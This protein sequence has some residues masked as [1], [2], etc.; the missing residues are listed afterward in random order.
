MK[1]LSE[2]TNNQNEETQRTVQ[3]VML[4]AARENTGSKI[5]QPLSMPHHEKLSTK[6]FVD[7]KSNLALES[8]NATLKSVFTKKSNKTYFP[9]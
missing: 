7:L 2:N 4:K 3:C 6:H 8:L 5:R 1:K 9:V